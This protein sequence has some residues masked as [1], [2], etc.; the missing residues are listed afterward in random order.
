[1]F[2]VATGRSVTI[3]ELAGKIVEIVGT[4]ASLVHEAKRAGD[5]RNSRADVGK[6]SGW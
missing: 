3:R 2:N 6:I 5:V 4:G 1:V